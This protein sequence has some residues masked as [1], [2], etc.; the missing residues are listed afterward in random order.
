MMSTAVMSDDAVPA[1][2]NVV[3]GLGVNRIDVVALGVVIRVNVPGPGT[4]PAGTGAT[5]LMPMARQATA[6][7]GRMRRIMRRRMIYRAV[8]G[9][10]RWPEGAINLPGSA[11]SRL[12][13]ARPESFAR[14]RRRRAGGPA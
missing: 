3:T 6:R 14:C 1:T 11:G 12:R 10:P 2:W 13:T 4:A 5:A 9:Q 7:A 8:A